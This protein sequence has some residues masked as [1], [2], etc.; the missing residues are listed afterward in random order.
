M[1][2]MNWIVQIE[3]VDGDVEGDQVSKNKTYKVYDG[4]KMMEYLLAIVT[5]SNR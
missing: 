2:H 1:I 5:V 3:C 4:I